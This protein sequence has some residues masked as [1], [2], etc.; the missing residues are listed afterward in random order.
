M[1]FRSVGLSGSYLSSLL[2][3]EK[4]DNDSNNITWKNL[5]G[6]KYLNDNKYSYLDTDS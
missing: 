1:L 6:G 5:D 4:S 2:N 3:F